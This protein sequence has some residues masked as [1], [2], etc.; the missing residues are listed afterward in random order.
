MSKPRLSVVA[1]STQRI[2]A[3]AS[4]AL[5]LG[6]FSATLCALPACN[7]A[8]PEKKPDPSTENQLSQNT[9]GQNTAGQNTAGQNQSNL[10]QPGANPSGQ[11]SANQFAAGPTTAAN[12]AEPV[13]P[14][15][16]SNAGS[17][18]TSN[19]MGASNAPPTSL[20]A[21][22]APSMA[23]GNGPGIQIE[24][25]APTLPSEGLNT[26]PATGDDVAQR[27]ADRSF[28]KLTLPENAN[29]AKLM[30][31]LADCDRAVQDLVIA[32]QAQQL[33]ETE[34]FGQAKRLSGM[35]LQAAE[36]LMT[37]PDLKPENQ[38]TAVAA[39]IE[40]LSQLTGLGDVQAAQKL[41]QRATDLA[42]SSDPQ[43]VHQG[44]LVLLGFRLNQFQEGQLKDPQVVLAEIDQLF[45]RVED[46][47]LVELIAL[48]QCMGVM[49]Q[50]GYEAEARQVVDRIV[51]NY[52][53][54]PDKDLSMR[55]WI[56]ETS[57]SPALVN[58]N[59]AHQGT[60]QGSQSDPTR[61]A[62]AAT[63]LM[64]AFPS[65]NTVAY[66]CRM[67]IDVEFSGNVAAAA[68][69][70]NAIAAGNAKLP[71]N[72][73]TDEL[74]NFLEFHKRRLALRGRPV[75]LEELIGFD[76]QPFDWNSYR[77][78]VVLVCFW[79]STE[80]HSLERC[81]SYDN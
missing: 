66:C 81:R 27:L 17:A 40:S 18:P 34:F 12:G 41:Q 48:Q 16:T 6:L 32:R 63:E 58:F 60:L 14:P 74:N 49:Q 25:L 47:S 1:L 15:G 45:G 79:S 11:L 23:T 76:G 62:A 22:G 72:S 30:T 2:G 75:V 38:K 78:K 13:L 7:Q 26:A 65:P 57:G 73:F 5:C 4:K 51:K 67:L 19:A 59:A 53:N 29:A 8:E 10:N 39:Q 36:M 68:E 46:R 80:I 54:L 35:K 37:A 21:T 52:R 55:A 9:A 70:G 42:R 20:A 64:Q 33:N 24:S 50:L 28:V 71:P 43:L 77:G 56:I 31:F 3:S 44:K 69:L 61:L